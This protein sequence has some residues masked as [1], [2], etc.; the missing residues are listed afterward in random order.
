MEELQL[1]ATRVTMGF[2]KA[3]AVALTRKELS[4]ASKAIERAFDSRS[5]AKYAGDCFLNKHQ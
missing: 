2:L 5:C 3:A 4:A 1:K